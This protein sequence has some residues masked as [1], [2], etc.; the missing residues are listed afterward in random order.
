MNAP[1]YFHVSYNSKQN[2]LSS[3]WL[4]VVNSAEYRQA[5]LKSC[6]QLQE[7]NAQCWLVDFNNFTT[8]NMSDQSWTIDLL[9]HNLPHTKLQKLALVLPDNLFLEVVVEKVSNS[10]LNMPN[11]KVQIAHF[12]DPEAAQQWLAS[13]KDPCEG[14]FRNAS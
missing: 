12:A 1:P 7:S 4:R 9:G 6:K 2:L 11:N 5:I 13:S 10:L 3:H 14:L 8:P